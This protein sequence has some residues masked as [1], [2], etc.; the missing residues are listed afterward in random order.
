MTAYEAACARL[1]GLGYQITDA[2]APALMDSVARCEAEI[3]SD[4]R[5]RQL[6]ES[7]QYVLA[8]MAAGTF[9]RDKLEAGGLE[10]TEEFDLS[11]PAKS[12]SEGDVSVTFAGASDGVRCAQARFDALLE[13]L[14][15]PPEHVLAVY[16]RLAW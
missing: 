12:V 14:T 3:L 16:R 2:D 7:L 1:A 13:R 15:R 11:A 9:L 6:P 4:I 10:E 5:H 8:D